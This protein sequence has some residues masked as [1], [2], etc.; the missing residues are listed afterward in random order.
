MVDRFVSAGI[1]S[2]LVCA[3]AP[4][5]EAQHFGVDPRHCPDPGLIAWPHPTACDRYT[6]CENGTVTEEVCP[7]GLLFDPKGGIFDF[8]NYNWR[9]D[10]GERLEKP[11]PI[12]SP[13]CPWQFGVFPSA[14]CVEYFKCEWGHAN[15]THCE[16]GLAYDDATHSCNW[17]DLVD[18]C[19]SEA[20][21][22]FRCPDKVTGPGAKFYPY[23]R[24]PH[25][26]DCTRLITCVHDKPRLI[27]CGYGSA[28][29][30][31]SYTCEDAANVPDCPLVH[32]H[33]KK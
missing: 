10:C 20:I 32:G 2:C 17:P 3:L 18:G 4:L 29:S 30:H 26:A 31:Y 16:P 9:V 15:L 12:P 5:L 13:D 6:R 19:D 28:F 21:V 11:G 25:P 14:S 23:P 24:Y 1:L 22:G 7:N 8:C 27:S 33:K